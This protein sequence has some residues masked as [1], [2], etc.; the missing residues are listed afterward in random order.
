IAARWQAKAG[1]EPPFAGCGRPF[2][3]IEVAL[4]KTNCVRFCRISSL[5]ACV[6]FAGGC[7]VRIAFVSF[8]DFDFSEFFMFLEWRTA[9][10]LFLLDFNIV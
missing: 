6:L 4:R 2:S 8:L 1:V 7:V 10:C 9:D 5:S 3:I